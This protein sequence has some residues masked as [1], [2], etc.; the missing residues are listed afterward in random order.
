[1]I[2]QSID[3]IILSPRMLLRDIMPQLSLF[4]HPRKMGMSVKELTERKNEADQQDC[5]G[6]V[7]LHNLGERDT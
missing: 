3:D 2:S 5:T 4:C 6:V 7:G 1:M